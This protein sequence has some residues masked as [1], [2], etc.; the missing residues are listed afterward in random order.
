MKGYLASYLL[1]LKHISPVKRFIA[2]QDRPNASGM[3]LVTNEH[4][5]HEFIPF[6]EKNF[7]INGDPVAN[8]EIF[9]VADVEENKDYVIVISTSSGA[10]RYIVG[11]TIRFTDK[12]RCEIVITGRTKHYL[13]L[14]GEHL[15]VENMN[16]A[17]ELASSDMNISIPEF[18]V[19]GEPYENLFAHHWYVACDDVVNAET[20]RYKIDDYLKQLNDDYATERGHALKEVFLDVLPEKTFIQF[21][22]SLGKIGGQH[23]FPRVLKGKTLE[24]WKKFLMNELVKQ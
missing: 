18:T 22:R 9:T 24:D 1:I 3:R 11:D 7:D 23:K 13:S 5:F 20:L 15:S 21:M 2:Y 17:I 14:V 12:Q 10:W 19:V 4:I 16:K 6:D 8:P